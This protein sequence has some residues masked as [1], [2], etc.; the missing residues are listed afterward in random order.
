M[1]DIVSKPVGQSTSAL[2]LGV[3]SGAAV[4]LLCLAYAGVLSV[5]LL[6]LPSPEHQIQEPWFALMEVLI[7][8]I[9]PAMVALTVALHAWAPAGRKALALASVV[10]MSMSA[11]VTCAVHFPILT[12]GHQPEFVGE[13]WAHLI[14]SFRWPSVAYAL[15][16]LAWDVLFPLAALF[17]ATT[18]QGPGAASA[19]RAL[20]FASAALAFLGLA[21]VAL[22]DM[23]VRNV[24]IIGYAVLFPIAAALL[25]NLF[26]RAS[27]ENA[28]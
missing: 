15:D 17:A 4:A 28:A 2:R 14:F 9:A 23:Q 25:A 18:V 10:F 6:T 27:Y 26:R 11:V 20:L 16:I 19:V 21:G 24:G 12:L 1:A 7:I 3:A 22:A 5:G 13:P 8:G